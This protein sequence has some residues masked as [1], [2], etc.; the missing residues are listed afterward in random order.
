MF[1][2]AGWRRCLGKL[3]WHL[4]PAHKALTLAVALL[5]YVMMSSQ[6]VTYVQD[7]QRR[8]CA[9]SCSTSAL[10]HDKMMTPAAQD[11]SRQF[12]HKEDIQPRAMSASSPLMGSSPPE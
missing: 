9:V 3:L 10:L 1:C 12:C 5:R 2:T 6:E 4:P 8:R 7:E 11:K